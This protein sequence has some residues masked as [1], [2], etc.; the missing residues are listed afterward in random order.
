MIVKDKSNHN[1]HGEKNKLNKGFL[2]Y[3]FVYIGICILCKYVFQ[4]KSINENVLI[5][6]LS[7]ISALLIT[8]T[9]IIRIRRSEYEYLTNIYL[10]ALFTIFVIF[11][12]SAQTF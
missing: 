8:L 7:V 6:V 10:M 3:E 2:I 5:G 11:H 4:F 1:R 12:C 9:V